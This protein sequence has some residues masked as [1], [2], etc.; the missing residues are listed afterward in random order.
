MKPDLAGVN[1]HIG[2]RLRLLRGKHK[3]TLKHIGELLGVSHQQ[4]RNY[5]EGVNRLTADALFV[6]SREMKVDPGFFLEGLF[7]PHSE[8]SL[9]DQAAA[10]YIAKSSPVPESSRLDEAFARIRSRQ[11]RLLAVRLVETVAETE[12]DGMRREYSGSAQPDR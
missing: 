6:L 10:D 9:T 1:R 4:I 8:H 11:Q 3:L 12:A 2:D 5:E 7:G